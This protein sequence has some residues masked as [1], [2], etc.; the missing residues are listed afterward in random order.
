VSWAKPPFAAPR[1]SAVS[2]APDNAPNDIAETLS[3]A[4]S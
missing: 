3:S 2:A 1:F 4:I